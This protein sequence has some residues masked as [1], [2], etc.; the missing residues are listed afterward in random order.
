[1]DAGLCDEEVLELDRKSREQRDESQ[2]VNAAFA[3]YFA[4]TPEGKEE[5]RWLNAVPWQWVDAGRP[6]K[7]PVGGHPLRKQI[8]ARFKAEWLAHRDL[9]TPMTMVVPTELGKRPRRVVF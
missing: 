7:I 6:T 1:M 8:F 4:S 2:A 9:G 5:G 3:V